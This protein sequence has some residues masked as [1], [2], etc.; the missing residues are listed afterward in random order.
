MRENMDIG[1]KNK[2]KNDR[3]NGHNKMNGGLSS[4]TVKPREDLPP[5]V[6]LAERNASECTGPER[7]SV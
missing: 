5:L 1:K 6:N 4:E 3:E 7:R 2:D